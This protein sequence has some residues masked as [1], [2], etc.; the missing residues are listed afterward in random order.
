VIQ[1]R[2]RGGRWQALG[3]GVYVTFTGPLP[4]RS[5][6]WAAV[7]QAGS[8]AMLSHYS[9]AEADGLTDTPGTPIHVTVPD[10]RRVDAI[11]G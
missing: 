4:R 5:L 1:A 7:L 11:S 8:G 10:R 2:V 6:L 9:A 3:R